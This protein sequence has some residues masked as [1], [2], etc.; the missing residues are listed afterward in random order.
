[1]PDPFLLENAGEV[2]EGASIA[3]LRQL[4]ATIRN[5]V[6]VSQEPAS[7]SNS[8]FL[9]AGVPSVLH[10]ELVPGT[11][12]I[13]FEP[14]VV[15]EIAMWKSEKEAVDRCEPLAA[16][17]LLRVAKV[18]HLGNHDGGC[19][20]RLCMQPAD[21]NEACEETFMLAS[22]QQ[23]RACSEALLEAISLIRAM[24]GRSAHIP[25]AGY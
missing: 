11:R 12:G 7:K 16:V 13:G 15:S 14:W 1:M 24:A 9:P 4:A 5:E 10:M 17:R 6:R 21:G 25:S 19:S 8:S 18:K 20:I 3:R 2:E 23:A 22:P